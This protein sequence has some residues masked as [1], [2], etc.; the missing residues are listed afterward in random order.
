MDLFDNLEKK[1]T[2]EK[3]T[4]TF[5]DVCTRFAKFETRKGQI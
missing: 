4:L 2:Y 1:I 3:N 5:F